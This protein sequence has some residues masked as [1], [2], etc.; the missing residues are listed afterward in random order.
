MPDDGAFMVA[1]VIAMV[2]SYMVTRHVPMMAIVTNVDNETAGFTVTPT[3]G[4]ET[5]EAGGTATFTVVLNSQPTANVTIT[6][7]S[8]DLTEGTVAPTQLTFTTTNWNAPQTVTVTGVDDVTTDGNQPYTITT[9]A[10]VST[11]ASYANLDPADVSVTN[12][13]N[14]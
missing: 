6:L 11:D 1:V 8:S 10:A 13:D 5:T 2:A 12:L 3:S 14:D 7:T 9:G 4:L